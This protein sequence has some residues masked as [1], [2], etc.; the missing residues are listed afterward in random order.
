MKGC[1]D[2]EERFKWDFKYLN[3]NNPEKVKTLAETE[4]RKETPA[5][6]RMRRSTGV[7]ALGRQLIQVDIEPFSF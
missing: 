2:E 6:S 7:S 4:V 3:L 5:G 1:K